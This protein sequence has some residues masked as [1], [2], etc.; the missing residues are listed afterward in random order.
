MQTTHS[1]L[2][3]RYDSVFTRTRLH[4]NGIGYYLDPDGEAGEKRFT[5]SAICSAMTL[6]IK[7]L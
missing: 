4:G 3:L 6:F 5:A 7:A 2:E 1:S